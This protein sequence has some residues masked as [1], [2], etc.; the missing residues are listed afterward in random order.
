MLHDYLS[1]FQQSYHWFLAL[2]LPFPLSLLKLSHSLAYLFPRK[3]ISQCSRKVY[4]SGFSYAFLTLL[5]N[6]RDSVSGCSIVC[7][8]SKK[9]HRCIIG[10]SIRVHSIAR[11]VYVR[12]LCYEHQSGFIYIE[13]KNNYQNK[14]F[15]RF[16]TLALKER[17]RETRKWS[18]TRHS[19]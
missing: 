6:T 18:V 8:H 9:P 2:S 16:F 5:F 4:K 11:R 3:I 10:H 15:A 1:S 12:R 19:F 13:I 7:G 17:L 14:N